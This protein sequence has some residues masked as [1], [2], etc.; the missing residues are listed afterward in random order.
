MN[1]KVVIVKFQNGTQITCT[2]SRAM[3]IWRQ[4]PKEVKSVEIRYK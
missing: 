2:E 4:K 3:Q 1:N